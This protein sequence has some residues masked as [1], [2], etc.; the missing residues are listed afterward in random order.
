MFSHEQIQWSKILEKQINKQTKTKKTQ[1][2]TRWYLKQD[3]TACRSTSWQSNSP[4]GTFTSEP[5][6]LNN[7]SVQQKHKSLIS[8]H[9]NPGLDHIETLMLHWSMRGLKQFK[10]SFVWCVHWNLLHPQNL[11]AGRQGVPSAPELSVAWSQRG[12]SS[13]TWPFFAMY[14]CCIP[15][16]YPAAPLREVGMALVVEWLIQPPLLP[17]DIWHTDVEDLSWNK[18]SVLCHSC[19]VCASEPLA[20]RAESR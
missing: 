17:L 19:D 2:G 12:W 1:A 8:T 13:T 10:G 5:I 4:K 9:Y 16:R 6:D 3:S 20:Y 18:H 14:C 11:W 7:C 15:H